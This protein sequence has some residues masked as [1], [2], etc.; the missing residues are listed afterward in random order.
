M[1]RPGGLSY[2]A[3]RTLLGEAVL[4]GVGDCPSDGAQGNV[5]VVG[6]NRH[7]FPR[8]R[9][10]EQATRTNVFAMHGPHSFLVHTLAPGGANKV[11]HGSNLQA[12]GFPRA[13]HVPNTGDGLPSGVSVRVC[14]FSPKTL[15]TTTVS[16]V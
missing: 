13:I 16:I 9:V 2:I 4:G 6:R 14:G 8:H 5:G 3:K 12:V 1:D 10:L 7:S 11:H 15:D